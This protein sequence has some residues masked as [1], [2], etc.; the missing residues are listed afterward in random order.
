MQAKVKG[1]RMKGEQTKEM[2]CKVLECCAVQGL[3]GEIWAS[4]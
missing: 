1:K 3:P 4:L 2:E